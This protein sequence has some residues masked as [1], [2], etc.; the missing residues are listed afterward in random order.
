MQRISEEKKL[1]ESIRLLVASMRDN[2]LVLEKKE[3]PALEVKKQEKENTDPEPGMSEKTR[4]KFQQAMWNL[5][6]KM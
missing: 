2:A 3:Q 1:P 5:Q 4:A 6:G